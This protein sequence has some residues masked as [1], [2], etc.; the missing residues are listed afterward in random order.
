M[1]SI[2]IIILFAIYGLIGN[3]LRMH[4]VSSNNV[5]DLTILQ[6]FHNI[7]GLLMNTIH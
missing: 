5:E 2:I 6:I 4:F 1:A 7:A 3:Y